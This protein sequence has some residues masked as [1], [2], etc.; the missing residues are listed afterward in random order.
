MPL[1][2]SHGS[3][4]QESVQLAAFGRRLAGSANALVGFSRSI[5]TSENPGL[6]AANGEAHGAI[7]RFSGNAEDRLQGTVFELTDAELVDADAHELVACKRI[8]ATLASG[9][10]AWVYVDAGM[11]ALACE[12]AAHPDVSNFVSKIGDIVSADSRFRVEFVRFDDVT[13][14]YV[15]YKNTGS[16]ESP[17]WKNDSHES[18]R[19]GTHEIAIVEAMGRIPWLKKE[20]EWPAKD[21]AAVAIAEYAPGWIKCPFCGKRFHLQDPDRWGGGR[22]LTCGQKIIKQV[23]A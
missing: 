16:A 11:E 17:V 15:T 4:Q 1:L 10:Q 2:F 20:T 7:M 18:S 22:H 14:G 19:F 5:L 13:Y 9:C 3:L 21:Q 23:T 8:V 6:V 12:Y